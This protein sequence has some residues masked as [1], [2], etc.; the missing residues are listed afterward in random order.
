M[1]IE[2]EWHSMMTQLLIYADDLN[3]LD[4]TNMLQK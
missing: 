2:T 1:G 4:E 3:L